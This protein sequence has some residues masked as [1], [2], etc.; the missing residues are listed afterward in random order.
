MLIKNV[1]PTFFAFDV[2]RIGSRVKMGIAKSIIAA[3]GSINAAGETLCGP[4]AFA[5]PMLNKIPDSENAAEP[6]IISEYEVV[7]IQYDLFD[8]LKEIAM[9]IRAKTK[10]I[11]VQYE[12]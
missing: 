11:E 10:L 7:A 3:I 9:A 8:G 12:M 2:E 4:N 1:C 5:I 6:I